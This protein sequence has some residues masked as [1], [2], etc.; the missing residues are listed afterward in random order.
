MKGL[1]VRMGL[2]MTLGAA[3][4]AAQPAQAQFMCA[5]RDAVIE[6]LRT[7]YGEDLTGIGIQSTAQVLEVWAAPM[8]GTWTVLMSLADGKACI[9]ASGTDW[10]TIDPVPLKMGVPG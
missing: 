8:T 7:S 3:T 4:L 2:A 1:L 6:R 9:V 10:Q 5:P